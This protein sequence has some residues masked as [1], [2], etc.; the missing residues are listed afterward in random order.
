MI[1]MAKVA[2]LVSTFVFGLTGAFLLTA[3]ALNEAREY[4]R[5][6]RV[7]A[8]ISAIPLREHFVISRRSSRNHNIDSL[9]GA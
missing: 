4:T 8:R 1:Y 7:M 6:L 3:F 2:I 5:A 9:H